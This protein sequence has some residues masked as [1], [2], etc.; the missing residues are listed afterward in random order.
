MPGAS[1][2]IP[3]PGTTDVLGTSI[4]VQNVLLMNLGGCTIPQFPVASITSD[5]LLVTAH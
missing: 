4:A 2:D 5:T 3:I 1:V